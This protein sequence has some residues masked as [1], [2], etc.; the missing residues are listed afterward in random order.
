M[1]LKELS[2]KLILKLLR[3][4]LILLFIIKMKT[5]LVFGATGFLGSNLVKFLL[6]KEL[7]VIIYK[8]KSLRLLSNVTS[9]NLIIFDK[10]NH[11]LIKKYKIDT[12]FHLASKQTKGNPTFKDFYE[13][14]V[15]ITKKIIQI[16]KNINVKQFIYVSSTSVYSNVKKNP[17]PKNYYA[18]TKYIAEKLIEIELHKSDVQT[19]IVRFPS[20]Y[21]KDSNGGIVETLYKLAKKNRQI[22]VYNNGKTI[23]NLIHVSSAVKMLYYACINRSKLPK[24]EIFLAGSKDSLKLLTIAK[25]IVQYT[26]SK[27]KIIPVHKV[28]T[29][30]FDV[31]VDSSKAKKIVGFIPL[32]IK[33]GLKNYLK[34]YEE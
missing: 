26:K 22:K 14:N 32:S 24:N 10:L 9:K 6:A 19:C 7:K 18:L 21:G 8:H 5:I 33:N 16:S 3:N 17:D 11:R 30:D 2:K 27:S 29:S 15:R 12:I 25:L 1:T 20:I 34:N 13:V 4:E 23:R 31:K 28:L